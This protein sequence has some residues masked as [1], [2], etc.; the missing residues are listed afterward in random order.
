[1]PYTG[2][3][4]IF[5]AIFGKPFDFSYRIWIGLLSI[6]ARGKFCLHLRFLTDHVALINR[7]KNWEK[8][9]KGLRNL[10]KFLFSW[11]RKIVSG[12]CIIWSKNRPLPSS[13]RRTS[14]RGQISS[15][16][17]NLSK[18]IRILE[19]ALFFKNL[20]SLLSDNLEFSASSSPVL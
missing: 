19:W 11:E 16:L 6:R 18:T 8:T 13:L 10:I 17:I 14:S 9:C 3:P 1:M 4:L 2:S 5:Y 12:L 20:I 7:S 15:W